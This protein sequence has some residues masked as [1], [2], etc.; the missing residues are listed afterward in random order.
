[1]SKPAESLNHVEK[2]A[3][4]SSRGPQNL[5]GTQQL[6]SQLPEASSTQGSL[7]SSSNSKAP[8][9]QVPLDDTTEATESKNLLEAS[10]DTMMNMLSMDYNRTPRHKPPINNDLP[11]SGKLTKP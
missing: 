5:A 4:V 7:E 2:G 1:M 8:L 10:M 9:S 3:I 11:L 6:K